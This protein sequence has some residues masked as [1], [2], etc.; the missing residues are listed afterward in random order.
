M[1]KITTVSVLNDQ[2]DN[3]SKLLT[4]SASQLNISTFIP[5]RSPPLEDIEYDEFVRRSSEF[6]AM[7]ILCLF[8]TVG[9][10]H[11]ILVYLRVKDM[12]ERIHVRTLIIWL[13]VIDLTTS[14]VVMP[15]EM[16]AFRWRYSISSNAVC[17]LFRYTAY[18]T[19][20]S[21]WLILTVIG[22][23]RYKNIYGILLGT[24]SVLP[25]KTCKL[26]SWL[27]GKFSFSKHNVACILVIISSLIVSTPVFVFIGI[28][29]TVPL[30]YARLLGTQCTTQNKYRS[31]L[32]AGLYAGVVG[33]FAIS[34]FMYC[35]YCYGKILYLIHKQSKKEKARRENSI[36]LRAKVHKAQQSFDYKNRKPH[37]K[38]TIS[39]IVAT[40]FSLCG[41]IIFAI[42]TAFGV[43]NSVLRHAIVTGVMKRG[44]FI[45]NAC[46]PI[47]Y[48]MCD[49]KFRQACKKLYIK[50]T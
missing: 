40:G 4:T 29:D 32:T 5:A 20:M 7:V 8:G 45:N 14:F 49:S 39:L 44:S 9:N 22:H 6:S 1:E 13:S 31:K 47:I 27:K 50:Q 18:T 12:K 41:F 25:C 10:V 33:L 3:Y 42:G 38:V 11:T 26:I 2:V 48:F 46:N 23:E 43:S 17:K 28:V 34:C 19:G 16:V 30:N 24:K 15:F 37:Y 21:S 35:S 36:Y